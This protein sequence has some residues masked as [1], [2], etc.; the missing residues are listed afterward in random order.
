[1]VKRSVSIFTSF[2]RWI[3]KYSW[4]LIIAILIA[5]VLLA[6]FGF[7]LIMIGKPAKQEMLFSLAQFL[8]ACGTILATI[9]G[10][11][12]PIREKYDLIRLQQ[13][14]GHI[15]ICGL[16]DKGR[17]LMN[18]FTEKGFR[19]VIIEAQKDHP[20]IA[21]CR[22][23]NVL[24]MIG[25]AAD[26]VVLDEVNT[27]KAKYLFA[28]SGDDKTN[29]NI[30]HQ[31][32]KLAEASHK[33]DKKIFLRCYAHVASSSLQ[34]IFTRHELFAKTNDYF[35]ASIFNVYETSARVIFEKYPP[36]LYAGEQ[37]ISNDTI[38]IVVIGFGI[39]GEN[40]VRQAARVGHYARWTR[41]E[42][43]IVDN[44][45]KELSEKFFALYGD[46]KT[47]SSF[48]VP[49]IN[50]NFVDLDPECLLSLADIMGTADQQP[51]AVYIAVDDD[52][53]GISL[54]L[55]IRKMLGSD[56]TPVIV[57]MRS[58]LSELVKGEEARFI[59]DQNIY[60]FN[61]N[62]AACDYQVLI[63]EITD[64]LAQAVHS[65]YVNAQVL[66]TKD[67][68]T[69]STP[70]SLLQALVQYVPIMQNIDE[71]NPINSLNQILKKPDLYDCLR[72]K[73][74][75]VLSPKIKRQVN[76]TK[77]LRSKIF[78]SLSVTE[79][80]QILILN[81]SMLDNIYPELYPSP[82][83]ENAA[84]VAWEGLNEV[85]KD[86]NRWS[87]DH[88]SVKLRCIGFDGQ[89][90]SVFN[91][92]AN[93]PEF[94][95]KLSEMEHRRWM[96]ERL[97]DGW[98]YGPKRDNIKKIH[99]LLIPYGQLAV[100]EKDKDKDMIQNI[101]NLVTSAGWKQQRSFFK[102]SAAGRATD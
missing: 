19:V 67:D 55:R 89:D 34:N 43:S 45:I 16:G 4:R 18:T 83:R 52:S 14:S 6:I 41:L 37:S 31:G 54:A 17:R 30:A 21:G 99:D 102:D 60:G 35:D 47:P 3:Q 62:G 63:E 53:I 44:N 51:V 87:A 57:C 9:K 23:R 93:D 77:Y 100:E 11:W 26:G 90:L 81:A 91:K 71:Q 13:T 27:A 97:M 36:D 56:T 5:A 48:A 73:R 29:I 95:E 59:V 2:G 15:V 92:V 98:S 38:P 10:F 12:K 84:L 86:A 8:A 32:E 94:F 50:I 64:E 40:I 80:T 58:S 70:L 76:K 42:V 96:A 66:F 79:Q 65:A 74:R 46:G 68:F 25:D 82:K 101:K 28:V 88:L 69:H 33:V 22:E 7:L 49:D 39:M 78:S 24:V 85:M 61:I 1:M 75:D 20:D 72:A